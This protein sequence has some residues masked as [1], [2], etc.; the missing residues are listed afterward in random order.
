METVTGFRTPEEAAFDLELPL[1][2]S[3]AAP[4]EKDGPVAAALAAE[5]D[6]AREAPPIAHRI[7]KSPL[8]ED[9]CLAFA[10]DVAPSRRAALVAAVAAQ[11]AAEHS[12]VLVDGDLRHAHLSFDDRR[13]AQ[14]GLVDVLRYG[15]RSPR[16]VAPTATPGLAL[17]PVGSRTV[18]LAGTYGAQAVP[19]LFA[20]L[21]R[22]GELLVVNG[23]DLAD[24]D[25][26]EPFL[27]Q[28]PAWVLL[29]E[30]GTSDP[31]RTRALRDRLGRD[32]CAGIVTL[33]GAH[34]PEVGAPGTEREQ[35]WEREA[36][37]VVTE[38]RSEMQESFARAED[39]EEDAGPRLDVPTPVRT[40]RRGL[41]LGAGALLAAAAIAGIFFGTKRTEP[42]PPA[43]SVA[44]PSASPGVPTGT[45]APVEPSGTTPI[46]PG[47]TPGTTPATSPAAA[48][49]AAAAPTTLTPPAQA[50][51]T[52]QP[53][54]SP[55]ATT[56]RAAAPPAS[57]NGEATTGTSKTEAPKTELTRTEP[58]TAGS[59]QAAAPKKTE[60]PKTAATPAPPGPA[61]GAPAP[62][63]E[64]VWGVHVLSVTTKEGALREAKTL[65]AGVRPTFVK[66]A[67][68]PGK[69]TWWRVY[70]GP[71]GTREEA[72]RAAG[73]IKASGRDYAQVY[74]LT[75]ADIEAGT[76]RE[77]R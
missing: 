24:L 53:A 43:G 39:V 55:A 66:A 20:E 18:D 35:P 72:D 3:T 17:L 37:P 52:A 58:P 10:G 25:L 23:P 7:L 70:V 34:A 13:R 48:A 59:A 15:V 60:A 49:P 31:E 64:V 19:A 12:V 29:H 62:L 9:G 2:G 76:G 63:G 5:G 65:A 68:V 42:G 74:R 57:A 1:F 8:A 56:P 75:R 28:I 36:A 44:P 16:V 38:A 33:R 51:T 21:R 50:P 32:R 61:A 4:A 47:A 46:E 41:L 6:L 54:T 14:E 77:E 30:L 73:E 69:G 11:I 22:G 26:A 27:E 45:S 40:R 67:E 71:F